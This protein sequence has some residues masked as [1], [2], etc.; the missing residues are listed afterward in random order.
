M[1]QLYRAVCKKKS[2]NTKFYVNINKMMQRF[3][4]NITVIQNF[5]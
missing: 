1:K 2:H 4:V 3:Y 5:M